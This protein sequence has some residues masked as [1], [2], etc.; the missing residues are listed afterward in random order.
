MKIL[1]I[2]DARFTSHDILWTQPTVF[3]LSHNVAVLSWL[4]RQLFD[5]CGWFKLISIRPA[6]VKLRT[7][8]RFELTV[9]T[10]N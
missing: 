7:T 4:N 8:Y 1:A 10:A 5:T 6:V 2:Q 3:C 9:L